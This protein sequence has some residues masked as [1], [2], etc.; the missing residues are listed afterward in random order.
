MVA[1]ITLFGAEP[2]GCGSLLGVIA[3]LGPPPWPAT[4]FPCSHPLGAVI[5]SSSSDD[6]RAAGT[7]LVE[8]VATVIENGTI[9][10]DPPEPGTGTLDRLDVHATRRRNPRPQRHRRSPSRRRSAYIEPR[11][12]AHQQRRGAGAADHRFDWSGAAT[13]VAH[14]GGASARLENLLV[15]P[16]PP[17]GLRSARIRNRWDSRAARP[18]F[19]ARRRLRAAL[20]SPVFR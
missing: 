3:L 6:Q 11:R 7:G 9:V 14:S 8:I 1:H 5:N 18:L 12:G 15:G 17:S 19:G 2:P 16:P 20:V 13:I 10:F 4:R